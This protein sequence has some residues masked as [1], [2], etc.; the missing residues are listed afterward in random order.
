MAAGHAVL[1]LAVC[2]WESGGI[3]MM[4][5]WRRVVSVVAAILRE[6]APER[7]DR[8]ACSKFVFGGNT[9]FRCYINESSCTMERSPIKNM[10]S[11]ARGNSAPDS[12]GK[13][14][15]HPRLNSIQKLPAGR[16][17]VGSFCAFLSPQG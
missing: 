10:Y 11:R 9:S 16:I 3:V 14:F 5:G 13:Q 15:K 4:E 17:A 12:A 1:A 2:S 8:G 7:R 6:D